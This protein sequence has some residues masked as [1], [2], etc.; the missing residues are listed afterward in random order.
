MQRRRLPEKAGG[1]RAALLLV[2]AGLALAAC[3]GGK[4][5]AYDHPD[6]IP[7]GAGLF[8]GKK[9]DFTLYRRDDGGKTEILK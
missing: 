7:A 9:G 5:F 8:T 6:E 2:A 1:A 3:A 4:P